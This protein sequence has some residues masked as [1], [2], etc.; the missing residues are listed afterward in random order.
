[1]KVELHILQNFP[2]ANLNRDDTGSPKDC[3][4]GGVRRGRVS[5]QCLKRSIRT[6]GAFHRHLEDR[7]GVRTKKAADPVAARLVQ[8]YGKD[9][10]DAESTA[11]HVLGALLGWDEKKGVTK[12]LF[13]VGNDEL[14]QLA[15]LINTHW[16][17]LSAALQ[18]ERELGDDAKKADRE[19]ASKA[20]KEAVEAVKKAF[21][22][23]TKNHVGSVDI[24]LFG[25]MLADTAG[26]NI[27]AAC[28][29]AHAISTNK[30]D[31]DFDYYT[32]V[33][34]LNPKE[35]TGAGMI[36]TTGFNSSCFY[37]YA[38][39]DVDL[40]AQNLGGDAALAKL[41]IQAFIQAAVEAVPTGKQN[42]FA[43]QT[44]PAFVMTVVRP[45]GTMPWNLAN[46]FV[47][48]VRP[49]RDHD[50]V[51]ASVHE[52]DRHWQ[53]LVQMYGAST[54]G[55]FLAVTDSANALQHLNA[56]NV[57]SVRAVVEKVGHA[58]NGGLA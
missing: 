21:T 6:S 7:I 39:I 13:Y 40:L 27:D 17:A 49:A 4:F 11:Q 42:S 56:A 47:R 22:K 48:P 32:A 46:A 9:T 58:L 45:D 33:D 44:P 26:M 19:K 30:V 12:V 38:L 41:G 3:E 37:R 24:A 28:Q 18:Q 36:G 14:D 10:E 8:H 25:R 52:L 31:M 50:L 51:Y 2:P 35:E 53:E 57:G 54:E 34:D 16:D 20:T 43:P 29:V 55:V 23:Q 1:M 5:S 15:G